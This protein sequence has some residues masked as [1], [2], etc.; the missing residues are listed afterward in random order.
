MA[1]FQPVIGSGFDA[2]AEQQRGWSGFNA[3]VNRQN[4]DSFQ[5][6]TEARNNYFQTVAEMQRADAQRQQQEQASAQAD[7]VRQYQFNVDTQLEKGQQ[8]IESQKIKAQTAAKDYTD[9]RKQALADAKDSEIAADALASAG[10]F[11]TEKELN[12]ALPNST[13]LVKTALWEKNQQARQQLTQQYNF[14]GDI[15][16]KE[17]L[18]AGLTGMVAALPTSKEAAA[19]YATGADKYKTWPFYTA[20]P[21]TSWYDARKA[22]MGGEAAKLGQELAPVEKQGLDQNGIVLDPATGQYKAASTPAWLQTQRPA[23]ASASSLPPAPPNPATRKVGVVYM[24]PN[25]TP[26]LWTGTGWKPATS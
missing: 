11:D 16:K 10:H 8:A 13:P 4:L 15:A 14:T 3:N 1:T 2:L 23:G 26:V 17:N 9:A 21:D 12:D 25:G 24:A 7:A 19:S 22:A 5:R 18:K 6:A 20:P